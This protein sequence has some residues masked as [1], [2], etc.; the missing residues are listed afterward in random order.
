VSSTLN[1]EL[2]GCRY[3][4]TQHYTLTSPRGTTHYK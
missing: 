2:F 4:Q 1:S 3:T